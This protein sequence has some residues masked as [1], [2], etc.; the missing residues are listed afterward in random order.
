MIGCFFFILTIRN[1]FAMIAYGWDPE[2]KLIIVG[3][4][5]RVRNPMIVGE[6]VIQVGE[7]ILFI[8]YGVAVLAIINFIIHTVYFVFLAEPSLERRFGQEYLDYK[9]NVP[10]WIPRMSQ[11]KSKV[12]MSSKIE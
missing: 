6:I 5:C 1:K 10:R 3:M 4:Y 8:S 11:W 2:K 9:N 7:A 12:V